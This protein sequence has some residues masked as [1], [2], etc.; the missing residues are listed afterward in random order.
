[1]KVVLQGNEAA[2]KCIFFNGI[3]ALPPPPHS[4]FSLKL[5]AFHFKKSIYVN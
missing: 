4:F 3:K 2:K 5:L 1:M